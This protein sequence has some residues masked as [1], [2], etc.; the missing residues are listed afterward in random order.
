MSYLLNARKNSDMWDT[1]EPEMARKAVLVVLIHAL[2]MYRRSYVYMQ[3]GCS[4][5]IHIVHIQYSGCST[6]SIY[7][8]VLRTTHFLM[9]LALQGV[10]SL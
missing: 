4:D 9:K 8:L 1:S 6:W 5:N 10:C 7:D 2:V 3:C